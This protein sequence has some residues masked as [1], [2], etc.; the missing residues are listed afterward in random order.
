MQDVKK[1]LDVC[2]MHAIFR[3]MLSQSGAREETIVNLQRTALA[4][5][6]G[7]VVE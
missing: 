4:A 3:V 5:S 2:K 1:V 7:V 6:A